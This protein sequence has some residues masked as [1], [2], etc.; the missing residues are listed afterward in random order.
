[1]IDL[2]QCAAID[3][4]SNLPDSRDKTV[5]ESHHVLYPGLLGHLDHLLGFFGIAGDRFFTKHMFAQLHGI[6]AWF[7]VDVIGAAI[8]EKINVP[9]TAIQHALPIIRAAFAKAIAL[10]GFSNSFLTQ[11]TN[12]IQA[13]NRRR[14]V[15]HVGDLLIGIGVRL[16]HEGVS[17]HTHPDLGDLALGLGS[18]HGGETS[19]FTH[20]KLLTSWLQKP[21]QKRQKRG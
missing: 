16:A 1:M 15:H 8:V 20:A 17:K 11:A 4:V 14:R 13:G 7:H 21:R 12:Y 6:N 9:G 3:Q 19:F 2:P 18:G 5:V 10:Y